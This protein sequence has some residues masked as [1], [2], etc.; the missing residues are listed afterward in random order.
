MG[1][2]TAN[3]LTICSIFPLQLGPERRPY[4][5]D[6]TKG[7]MSLFSIAAA[8]TE[9]P[10]QLLTVTD[11]WQRVRVWEHEPDAMDDD[12]R[13]VEIPVEQIAADLVTVWTG[14]QVISRES[15]G[16]PGV[17]QIA[18]E[19]PTKA[20]L[21]RLHDV[22]TRF[23]NSLFQQGN[24]LAA[25]LQNN[26]PKY[27][28]P[29]HRLA[30]KWLHKEPVWAKDIDPSEIQACPAC[31]SKISSLASIC[32]VCQTQIAELPEG[33]AGF[34]RNANLGRSAKRKGMLPTAA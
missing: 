12:W 4:G 9:Q 29:L 22:Q 34:E 24:H 18:G 10:Y 20:E 26:G 2:I 25:D 3:T 30:A 15:G 1:R 11:C 8:T 14:G 33:L 23:F 28:T 31:M 13:P 17:M 7:G 21:K 19:E 27:I 32:P 16:T 6:R 5:P